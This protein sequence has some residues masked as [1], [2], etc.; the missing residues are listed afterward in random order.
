[1]LGKI[2]GILFVIDVPDLE[3]PIH[4]IEHLRTEGDVLDFRPPD[5]FQPHRPFAGAQSLT[6]HSEHRPPLEQGRPLDPKDDPQDV[7]AVEPVGTNFLEGE[8]PCCDGFFGHRAVQEEWIGPLSR[9]ELQAF[10]VAAALVI[11]TKFDYVAVWQCAAALLRLCPA[12]RA[13]EDAFVGC[14][15]KRASIGRNR[16]GTHPQPVNDRIGK[17]GGRAGVWK[18]IHDQDEMPRTLRTRKGIDVRNIDDWIGDGARP[19]DVIG[20]DVNL[21]CSRSECSSAT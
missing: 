12:K 13:V 7:L 16:Y 19:R 1:M 6:D 11:H 5:A 2:E 8:L 17:K 14:N 10:P 21:L 4:R 15:S 18:H 9:E 20:H 3:I